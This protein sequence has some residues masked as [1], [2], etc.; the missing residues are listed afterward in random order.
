[1]TDHGLSLARE[2]GGPL[3]SPL[4]IHRVS[5]A[6]CDSLRGIASNNQWLTPQS[7]CHVLVKVS[8]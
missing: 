2:D 5:C 4:N 6:E 3:V 7:E 8:S 1:M